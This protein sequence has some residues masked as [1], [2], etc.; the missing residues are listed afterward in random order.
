M[1]FY[2]THRLN[3]ATVKAVECDGETEK[4]VIINGHRQSKRSDWD[5][6]FHT[7]LE[8]WNYLIAKHRASCEYHRNELHKSNT[9]LGQCEAAVKNLGG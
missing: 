1:V 3:W 4:F 9:A 6:Y 7:E 8:A 5:N 2:K